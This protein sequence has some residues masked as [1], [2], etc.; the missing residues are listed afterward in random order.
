MSGVEYGLVATSIILVM[1]MIRLWMNPI[2]RAGTQAPSYAELL[3]ENVSLKATIEALSEQ[4]TALRN[5]LQTMDTNRVGLEI[6]LARLQG[7]MG[8][9]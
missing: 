7:E 4:N 9:K 2:M 5:R 1:V 6:T 8:R 3:R